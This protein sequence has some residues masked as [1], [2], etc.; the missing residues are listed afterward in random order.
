MGSDKVRPRVAVCAIMRDE[1]S[2]V[3]EWVAYYRAIGFD[4]IIIYDHLSKD[5]TTPIC[6]ALARAGLIHHV[7]WTDQPDD[8]NAQIPAYR[9]AAANFGVDWLCCLDADEYLVFE[10]ATDVHEWLTRAG[11]AGMPI[12]LNWKNFGSGGAIRQEP[13]LVIDRFTRRG[14]PEHASTSHIKT[15]G[16]IAALEGGAVVHVHGWLPGPGHYYVDACGERVDVYQHTFVSPPRWRC[17][18]INHY[19]V[20]SLEEYEAKSRRGRVDRREHDP[21]KRSQTIDNYFRPLDN[22][23]YGDLA[24][25]R[26]RPR[27]MIELERIRGVL[28]AASD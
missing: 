24:I 27:L 6:R 1:G 20:K 26:F 10:H 28:E 19:I 14:G 22:N 5:A 15:C 7:P 9:H 2:Y 13:G 3:V 16:P 18:W 17:A 4:E 25:R 12:S 21:E 23:D 8:Q 11:A